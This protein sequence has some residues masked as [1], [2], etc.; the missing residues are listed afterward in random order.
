M[1]LTEKQCQHAALGKHADGFGLYLHVTSKGKYWRGAYRFNG[2][3]KR[4][5]YGV[6][7]A[8]SLKQAR[9][10]HTLMRMQ[11]SEGIDPNLAKRQAKQSALLCPRHCAFVA[12]ISLKQIRSQLVARDAREGFKLHNPVKGDFVCCVPL[13]DSVLTNPYQHTNAFL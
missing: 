1:A 12:H 6:Y 8:V 11:L 5:S 7:P 9:E 13:V 4:A 10:K 2:K 3:Q